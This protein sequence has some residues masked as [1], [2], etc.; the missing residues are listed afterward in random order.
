M[1][2]FVSL[3][4]EASLISFSVLYF[5]LAEFFASSPN[6]LLFVWTWLSV[7]FWL[8]L[9][10][11]Y[12]LVGSSCWLC[13]E[14]HVSGRYQ[15]KSRHD[16]LRWFSGIWCFCLNRSLAGQSCII[17]IFTRKCW[18]WWVWRFLG[19]IYEVSGLFWNVPWVVYGRFGLKEVTHCTGSDYSQNYLE[20][21]PFVEG[22]II[23]IAFGQMWILVWESKIIS[24]FH[25]YPSPR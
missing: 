13:Q 22:R 15:E 6:S 7:K 25:E 14:S 5:Q 19:F 18:L 17:C 9:K 23:L 4:P 1:L 8:W 20:S 24:I 12:F 3:L 11:H 16:C 10:N 21:Y 2:L